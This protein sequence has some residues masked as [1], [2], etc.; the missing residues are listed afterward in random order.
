MVVE[1]HKLLRVAYSL[2]LDMPYAEGDKR[3]S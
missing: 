1:N 2:S 3:S